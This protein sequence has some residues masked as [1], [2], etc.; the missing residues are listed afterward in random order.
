MTQAAAKLTAARQRARLHLKDLAAAL[1]VHPRT[2]TRW[3]IGETRPSKA[4]WERAVAY[5]YRF[6][7]NEAVELAAAA[8]IASPLPPRVLV[9][10]RA[11]EDSISRAADALDVSPRRVRGA[12]REIARSVIAASGSLDDLAKAAEEPPSPETS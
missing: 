1:G 8:G 7:P 5:L 6:V 4:E 9:D 2:V 12:L 11:I 3:E 10:M